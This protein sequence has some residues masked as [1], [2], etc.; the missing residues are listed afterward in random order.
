VARIFIETSGVHQRTN[1]KPAKFAGSGH[2]WNVV[3]RAPNRFEPCNYRIDSSA[4]SEAISPGRCCCI[5]CA[6]H[7]VDSFIEHLVSNQ[8]KDVLRGQTFGVSA[9]DL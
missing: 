5:A 4:P 8:Q 6:S 9:R 1:S 3:D 7:M 2:K